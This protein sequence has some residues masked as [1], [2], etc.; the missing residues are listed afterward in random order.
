MRVARSVVCTGGSDASEVPWSASLT[1]GLNPIEE[2][3]NDSQSARASR[4]TSY[5]V[6]A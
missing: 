5:R 6:R 4:M 3:E 2:E 1:I